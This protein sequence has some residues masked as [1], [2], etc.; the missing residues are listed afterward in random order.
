L[1]FP[2]Q[3][4]LFPHVAPTLVAIGQ[5]YLL[6]SLSHGLLGSLYLFAGPSHPERSEVRQP[7]GFFCEL[8]DL[9][10]QDRL[11]YKSSW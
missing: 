10:Y 8:L 2:Y 3:E 1:A 4:K 6:E 9:Y 7:Y 11:R 5:A